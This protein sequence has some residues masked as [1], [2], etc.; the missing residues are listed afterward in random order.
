MRRVRLFKRADLVVS[1]MH[2]ERCHGFG[3]VMRLSRSDDGSGDDRILEHPRKRDLGHLD[4]AGFG[5]LLDG[6][7]DGFVEG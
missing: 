5:D 7:D 3:Q 4:A 6:V 1:E 2:V